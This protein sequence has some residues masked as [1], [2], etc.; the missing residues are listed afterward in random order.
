[1][2]HA[3]P[4]LADFAAFPRR[5]LVLAPHPDDEALGLGGT[6]AL[7]AAR[8]DAVRIV[9]ATDGAA[10]LAG[11]ERAQR[12]EIRERE[13]KLAAVELGVADVRFL[14]FPDGELGSSPKL[15]AALAAEVRDFAPEA[16]YLPSPF[17]YHGDHRALASVGA[18]VIAES[19]A[20]E[21]L[22]YGVNAPLAQGVLVDITTVRAKKRA[23]LERFASQRERF[24]FVPR[25]EAADRARALNC[26]L[27]GV[28]AL[29]GFVRCRARD[30]RRVHATLRSATETCTEP[31]PK[32]R[33]AVT[34]VLT[35]FN[36]KNDVLENLRALHAQT[37]PFAG[38]VVVDNCSSDGTVEAVEAQFP[39]V[40]LVRMPHSGYGACETFNI[41][42]ASATTPLVAILDD[43]VVLPPNWLERMTERLAREPETTAI[44]SCE[45]EEPG[46]P[47][48]Y[49]EQEHLRRERYMST[50]RGCASL[51]RLDALRR[52]DYYDVRLFIYGN[53]RDL[54]CRL[55]NLGYRVLQ[56]PAVRALHKTPF[57]IKMGKRSLYYHAR[58]AWLSMLKYA[59][60]S[61][62]V[63]LPWLVLTRV[64]L[65]GERRERAGTVADATGTIG[66]GKSLRE[67]PGAWWVLVRAAWG[68][69]VSVPY[70]LKH[71]QPCR[72][73]DFELPLK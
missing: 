65:R 33:P 23:A 3:F 56:Y 2:T 71:R 25:A 40:T 22:F 13:S 32:P 54:T 7:H 6:L 50:F 70:C 41:G 38:V 60:A 48:G 59:P 17:E 44:V 42:F 10:G 61:E 9:V 58:N 28:E 45:V 12:R 36:K 21:A 31:S 47:E 39:D 14:G 67:T 8:G 5:V 15:H 52:A 53:E 63:R 73:P 30:A 57:G 26:E 66:I 69:L 20:S 62:L 46:M 27:A 35:S 19:L 29:E 4:P 55:L 1:M 51:A 24:D 43:D 72:A 37:L 16:V 49:L 64:L 11:A 18:S 68:V 34:A